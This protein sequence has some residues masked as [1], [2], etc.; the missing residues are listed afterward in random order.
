MAA[1]F[2]SRFITKINMK[3]DYDR[4]QQ[5]SLIGYHLFQPQDRGHGIGTMALRLLIQYVLTET[6]IRRLVIITDIDNYASQRI[7]TKGGFVY[8]G[9]AREGLPLICYEWQRAP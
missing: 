1:L 5:E 4:E 8:R 7:A 9:P 3:H 2:T 6:Q